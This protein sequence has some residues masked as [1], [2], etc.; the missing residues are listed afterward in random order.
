MIL[1]FPNINTLPIDDS[2]PYFIYGSWRSYPVGEEITNSTSFIWR[3]PCSV[4]E[5]KQTHAKNC[6]DIVASLNELIRH[7]RSSS[8]LLRFPTWLKE[9]IILFYHGEASLN[10]KMVFSKKCSKL[11]HNCQNRC[12]ILFSIGSGDLIVSHVGSLSHTRHS[13]WSPRLHGLLHF[14]SNIEYLK[15]EEHFTCDSRIGDGY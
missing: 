6:S 11:P 13:L 7:L 15:R 5:R 12:S 2:D 14:F 4:I 8:W 3:K 9:G 10:L 1:C